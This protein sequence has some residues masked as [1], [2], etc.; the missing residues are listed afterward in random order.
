MHLHGYC[1]WGGQVPTCPGPS[2][3]RGGAWRLCLG[4][5]H[6]DYLPRS[7]GLLSERWGLYLLV[8][9]WG[10]LREPEWVHPVPLRGEEWLGI[11]SSS[12]N[13]KK[14]PGL[15]WSLVLCLRPFLLMVSGP[16]GGWEAHV[17]V[18]LHFGAQLMD[19]ESTESS[20]SP[21]M[22]FRAAVDFCLYFPTLSS[23]CPSLLL[24][25]GGWGV[26]AGGKDTVGWEQPL[27]TTQQG[28]GGGGTEPSGRG[29]TEQTCC[30][31][32]AGSWE[33]HVS[34]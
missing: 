22:G 17:C 26:A 16:R 20:E 34:H 28:R 24:N 32:P 29:P 10:D 33:H 15:V 14:C 11:M 19:R 18:N 5:S 23:I 4:L 6:R 1:G 31:H 3:W 8:C 12:Q 30:V 13:P 25:P 27:R 21:T 9:K 7:S 2:A